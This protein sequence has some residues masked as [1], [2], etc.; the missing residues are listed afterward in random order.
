[1][2]RRA[3]I[4]AGTGKK[5]LIGC[6]LG[7]G[8]PLLLSIVL[9][10]GGSIVI[11]KPFN[12]AIDAQQELV[13]AHGQR[14]DFAPDAA[15]L[16]PERLEKFIA[17]RRALMALCAD[18]SDIGRSMRRM[19]NL[20]KDGE[21]PSKAEAFHAVGDVMGAVFGLA[22][23][24]GRFAEV[25][26]E[27]LMAQDMG[28]GEYIW[29]YTLAYHSWL[30]YPPN[31]SFDP[32]ENQQLD[33]ADQRLLLDFARRYGTALAAADRIAEAEAW[34]AEADRLERTAAG[35]APWAGG[36][37]PAALAADLAPYRTELEELYCPAAASFEFSRLRKR[38]MSITSD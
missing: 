16:R 12:R 7:C 9:A 36:E 19:E 10:V 33:P 29:I 23:K 18:L 27:A 14:E 21:E 30:G 22:G 17:V 34:A 32:K 35:G 38:G 37:L 31:T 5:W 13:T 28:L 6:G 11:M 4:V 20:E 3:V 25:R 8:I 1:M 24:I 26:N 2:R 15:G